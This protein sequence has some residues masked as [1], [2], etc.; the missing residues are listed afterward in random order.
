MYNLALKNG[1]RYS[2][3]DTWTSV[4]GLP[5]PISSLLFL[6]LG[7]WYNFLFRKILMAIFAARF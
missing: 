2:G 4:S 7:F 5:S 3:M 6:F 1:Q